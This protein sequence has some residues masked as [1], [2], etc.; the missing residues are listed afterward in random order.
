M[1]WASE[2]GIVA[3]SNNSWRQHG[4]LQWMRLKPSLIALD[5]ISAIIVRRQNNHKTSLSNT[6][7]KAV[8]ISLKATRRPCQQT[9]Q[10]H[11]EG[12]VSITMILIP[13][14][15][16]LSQEHQSPWH[17]RD[18]CK[19]EALYAG[20]LRQIGQIHA[21]DLPQQ[22]WDQQHNIQKRTC[23]QNKNKKAIATRMPR[24]T[25]DN[26]WT[27]R[28]LSC[29]AEPVTPSL[30]RTEQAQETTTKTTI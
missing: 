17:K 15:Q 19:K 24:I 21:P 25:H 9:Q 11:C 5:A 27:S 18:G 12:V 6:T 10:E 2:L 26:F 28:K 30:V 1:K 23:K 3:T 4:Q 8:A 7:R 16:L 20:N 14:W 29:L 13:R 22:T